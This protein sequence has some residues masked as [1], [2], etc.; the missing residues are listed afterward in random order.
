MPISQL[1][2]PWAFV[3]LA[4]AFSAASS[5]SPAGPVSP[6]P[7][8]GKAMPP[9]TFESDRV[10]VDLYGLGS[11]NRG[12]AGDF[13]GKVARS[14]VP[15]GFTPPPGLLPQ[16]GLQ[17]SGRPGWG[18][19][20]GVTVLPWRH[21]GIAVDQSALGRL[22]G[23]DDPASADFGYLR[24]QTS[25]A[26]VLRLPISSVGLAPYAVAGGGAQYGN[27]PRIEVPGRPPKSGNTFSLAGQGFFQVGGGLEVRLWPRLG[28]FSDLRWFH[29]GVGG[30]PRDQMQLRYG[31]RTAF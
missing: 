22:P 29:S 27:S 17:F 6:Y 5:V 8:G 30:L 19:G 13:T 15:V 10:L 7:A 3:L 24:H 11:F 31:L 12:A 14:R 18:G 21:V 28:I 20:L 4:V 23:S 9:L 16:S 1:F 25:A 2:T 26:L